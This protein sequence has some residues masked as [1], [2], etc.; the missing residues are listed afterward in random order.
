MS[1]IF[2]QADFSDNDEIGID[3]DSFDLQEELKSFEDCT[4]KP[5]DILIRLYIQ[6]KKTKGGIII[7]NTKDIFHEIVGYVAKIGKCGFSG[8]RYKDW[9]HWYKVGDWVAFP[10]H[11][12]IRYT[13]KKLPVFS[14]VDDAPMMIVPD[15][16]YVK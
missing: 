12:G 6:P 16:R 13:Y 2:M 10:R 4:I 3:L 8:E 9:G 1:N 7:D 14:I 11:A 15:P 5:T